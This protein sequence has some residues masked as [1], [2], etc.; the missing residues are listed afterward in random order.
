MQAG[1]MSH[2]EFGETLF[3]YGGQQTKHTV[4]SD[5]D[6]GLP[7]LM[8]WTESVERRYPWRYGQDNVKLGAWQRQE[9][10]VQ[11]FN[12]RDFSD[13]NTYWPTVMANLQLIC[14]A[15][16]WQTTAFDILLD[17]VSLIGPGG[18]SNV[19]D[20]SYWRDFPEAWG[21]GSSWSTD[22]A[23]PRSGG[24]ALKLPCEPGTTTTATRPANVTP[25]LGYTFDGSVYTHLRFHYKVS[26][27][28]VMNQTFGWD[29]NESAAHSL[30]YG[31]DNYLDWGHPVRLMPL[32]NTLAFGGVLG[33]APGND[34]IPQFE[35][36]V[37][38]TNDSGDAHGGYRAS[39]YGGFTA[40]TIWTRHMV[41]LAEGA[42]V[43]ADSLTP[44]GLGNGSLWL[45]GTP[46][47]S[48]HSPFR[49]SCRLQVVDCSNI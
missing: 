40:D 32:V 37:A 13:W 29:A 26:S 44:R 17:S 46:C 7:T 35:E 3:I 18:V 21:N 43:V 15:P 19:D 23:V 42:L 41:L 31:G 34:Y 16:P 10:T 47:A 1:T 6:T 8:P 5:A 36:L 2:Y 27:S 24:R 14:V 49:L 20:F 28:F 48:Q 38:D 4:Q 33:N 45:V 11:W 25:A 22:T 39:S 12:G 9:S 30:L